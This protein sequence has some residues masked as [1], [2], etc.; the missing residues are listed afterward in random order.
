MQD[1]TFEKYEEPAEVAPTRMQRI[2][3][4]ASTAIGALVALSL[5]LALGLWFYR[6]GVRDAQNVPIIQSS[7]E[8]VKIRPSDPGGAV[9]PHQDVSSYEIAETA[10]SSAT[11][12]V[13][14]PSPAVP[15][16]ED[17]AMGELSKPDPE[18]SAEVPA[19][20][21][22]SQPQ[23]SPSAGISAPAPSDNTGAPTQDDTALSSGDEVASLIASLD[24]DDSSD[25][26][27]SRAIVPVPK[28]QAET[29]A[30]STPEDA[31]QEPASEAGAPTEAEAETEPAVESGSVFAPANSPRAPNRPSDLRARV[32]TAAVQAKQ[33]ET[34][35][36]SRAAN[37]SI[38]IQLAADPDEAAIRA[39]WRRI[40]NA[41]KDI[42][43][44]KALAV[45]TTSSGGTTFYRLRVGPF[46]SRAK[47]LAICE[48]LKARGQDC[49]VARNS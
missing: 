1:T 35:L 2:R 8:P 46:D 31:A 17:V 41:N 37:S 49:I 4:A 16:N 21:T 25:T 26:P 22:A 7:S 19:A 5:L 32:E 3:G 15:Q 13:I 43:R 12:A 42:L 14:A 39:R 9:A 23:T 33:D 24:S 45:Q 20:E 40:F 38:Q 34:D 28:D 30:P 44:D 29:P 48:A 6:L 47:A 18:A 27:A 11:A 36:A 10:P